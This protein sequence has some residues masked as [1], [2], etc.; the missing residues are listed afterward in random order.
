LHYNFHG[1]T[2]SSRR[3]AIMTDLTQ[4]HAAIDIRVQTIRNSV[5]VWPCAKG[6]DACCHRLAEVPSL[7]EAEWEM[8]KAGLSALS[9]GRLE[10]I[11]R[12][13]AALESQAAGPFVCPF[14]DRVSGACPVYAQRP[15][16]CRTYGFYVQRGRGVYCREIE[17]RESEGTLE[18][19]MW[20]N[21]DAVDARLSGLGKARPLNE[22]FNESFTNSG[23]PD[24]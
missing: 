12:E 5:A 11:R 20:G 21:H 2:I 23:Q 24:A 9:P 15:V 16:A 19:V 6:C 1:N 3:P 8:L 10:Q 4:L 14:L 17:L 18:G 22:W 13:V 7:T